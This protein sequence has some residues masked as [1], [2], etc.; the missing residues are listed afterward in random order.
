MGSEQKD[1]LCIAWAPPFLVFPVGRNSHLKALDERWR[2]PSGPWATEPECKWENRWTR[3]KQ[4]SAISTGLRDS[5]R[6]LSYKL[7]GMFSSAFSSL[8]SHIPLPKPHSFRTGQKCLFM[9][10]MP[11]LH[12]KRAKLSWMGK[13][14]SSGRSS[15]VCFLQLYEMIAVQGG[16]S[17]LQGE[18]PSAGCLCGSSSFWQ[19][20]LLFFTFAVEEYAGGFS[21][22]Q[23]LFC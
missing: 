10:G 21:L 12:S 11:W 3:R 18:L 9:A 16:P 23:T 20:K 22:F 2:K 5:H 19:L 1:T 17:V 13:L 7:L 14:V 8:L 4:S 15:G 6:L